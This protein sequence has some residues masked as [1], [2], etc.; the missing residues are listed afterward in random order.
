M[1]LIKCPRCD[2]NYMR[3]GEKYCKVCLREV[4][5]ESVQEEVELCSICNEAPAL[6]GKDVCFFCLKEMDER[7]DTD[8]DEE[9]ITNLDSMEPD[10]LDEIDSEM[11][12]M[13]PDIGDDVEDEQEMN[14]MEE[15]LSLETVQE[16]E[17]KEE[18]DEEEE[19]F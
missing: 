15:Q 17:E 2:L 12:G 18:N 1:K 11:D 6:P 4:K 7:K 8:S 5:G 16:D 10:N 14:K 19:E 13:L 9:E 3:E